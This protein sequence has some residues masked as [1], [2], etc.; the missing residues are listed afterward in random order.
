[1]S[2]DVLNNQILKATLGRIIG[3]DGLRRRLRTRVHQT[4]RLFDQVSDIELTARVFYQVR[5][6][7]NNRLYGFLINVCRFLFES[8]Q[9]LEHVGEYRFQDVL[10]EPERLRRIFEKFVRNFYRRNQ[11]TY[12]ARKERMYWAGSPISDADFALVPQMETDLTLR[13]DSRVI[14]VECKYTESIYQRNYF[15]GKFRSEHLYQLLAYLRNFGGGAE[16]IL[17]YPTAGI[18][19]D[20]TFILQG[21]RVRVTTV[22]L[23]RRW[24]EIADSLLALISPEERLRPPVLGHV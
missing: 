3:T 23:D 7:Q 12:T 2:P 14:V 13:G 6:H 9:P 17:L 16:G 22:D 8:L 21:H 24:P 19:V 10:R 1:M 18:A 15:T 20:Q 4:R 11:T 5:F